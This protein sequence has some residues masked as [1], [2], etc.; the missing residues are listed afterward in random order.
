MRAV[1]AIL[2]LILRVLGKQDEKQ[3][4]L[5]ELKLTETQLRS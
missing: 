1:E 4:I 2:K 3:D 5:E